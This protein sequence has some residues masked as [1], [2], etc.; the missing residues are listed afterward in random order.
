MKEGRKE[1]R[2]DFVHLPENWAALRTYQTHTRQ[3]KSLCAN[4][5]LLNK[6]S[7]F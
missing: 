1:G 7:S 6:N 2:K 4:A 5:K 3:A